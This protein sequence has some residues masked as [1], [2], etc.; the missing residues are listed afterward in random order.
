MQ[1]EKKKIFLV[2]YVS[3]AWLNLSKTSPILIAESFKKENI[4]KQLGKSI[5]KLDC[6]QMQFY[7]IYILQILYRYF[8]F[9]FSNAILLNI[10]M[11]FKGFASTTSNIWSKCV[12]W[13][14]KTIKWLELCIVFKRYKYQFIFYLKSLLLI[15]NE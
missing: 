15:K 7:Y 3:Q 5:L 8:L 4:E 9:L 6:F 11:F 14:G 13:A 10:F 2:L 12:V 1:N